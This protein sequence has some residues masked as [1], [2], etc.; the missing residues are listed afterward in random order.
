MTY[1]SLYVYGI[2]EGTLSKVWPQQGI[3]G[4][5]D[6]VYCVPYKDITAVVSNTPFEEY[7][8]TEE[9]TINHEKV[10]QILLKEHHTVAPM[11]FCTIVKDRD[12]MIKLLQSAYM[13]FKK[14]IL[15]IKNKEEYD[16]K[17]FLDIK[18]LQEE[19][20]DA[21]DVV[22]KSKEIATLFHE[23][24]STVAD[25]AVLEEQITDDMIMN[26]SF[27]LHKEKVHRF[28]DEVKKLDQQFTDVIK[29]RISGPTA[30]YNFVSMPTKPK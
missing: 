15:K 26:S 27:L 2:V 29:V 8:P 13:V 16:V 21:D 25:D 6:D 17:I 23:K 22:K 24:L 18:K 19:I 28:Y 10:I 12:D 30:P 11:R 14:N 5:N 9:H 4:R 7:D 20:K 1:T 3:G